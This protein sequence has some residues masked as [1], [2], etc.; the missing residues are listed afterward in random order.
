M[1]PLSRATRPRFELF[2]DTLSGR[3]LWL[4][5]AIILAIEL[6][7]M[8]PGLGRERQLWLWDRATHADLM[9]SPLERAGVPLPPGVVEQM[10]SLSGIDQLVLQLPGQPPLVLRTS[11]EPPPLNSL[12]SLGQETLWLSTWR[13]CLHL[14]GFGGTEM[15]LSAS[16]PTGDAA[17]LQ[18]TFN[19]SPLDA[20]LRG[21]ARRTF[22]LTVIVALI[23]GLLVF[24]LL[25]RMLVRPMRIITTSIINFREDPEQ[26]SESDLAWLAA[27]P[28]DE[29]SGAARELKSMQDEMRAALWRNARLAAVGTAVA[30]ISHDLR[31]ILS[32]ALLVSDRLEGASDPAIQRAAHTLVSAVERAAQLVTRTVDF[33]REGPPPVVRSAVPLFEVVEEAALVV[34]PVDA[35]IAIRNEVPE[36][37]VLPLDRAQ[38]YRVL[39]NLMRNAAEA[40]ARTIDV[41]TE[42]KGGLTRMRVADNGPGLPLRVQDRLFKPFTSSGRYG[43]TGLGL[44]IARDLIRAHGG[45][46]VLEETGPRGT[47][48][49]MDLPVSDT[50][51]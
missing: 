17:Q 34:R 51:V 29:I 22:T 2:G 5:V 13:A 14:L 25:D 44:A 12:V 10:L 8:L 42:T 6:V 31:N 46:L 27:R 40:G 16:S 32:S 37:L 19:E 20:D 24:A 33:A 49:G 35:A 36:A 50:P 15:Q 43:G 4:T 26:E 21:Y 3:V 30:K 18:I 7:V 39:V 28:E 41:T 48:F 38:I 11:Q 1:N 9:F 47:V 23:T 45:D